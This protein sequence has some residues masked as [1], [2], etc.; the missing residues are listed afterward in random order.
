MPG[1]AASAEEEHHRLV[2]QMRRNVLANYLGQ[3]WSGVMALAFVPVYIR[4]LGVEAYGLIGIFAVIQACLSWVDIGISSVMGREMARFTAGEQSRQSVG[5]RLRTLEIVSATLAALFA[6]LIWAA[7][8]YLATSWV[9]SEHLPTDSVA[10]AVALMGLIVSLRFGEAVYRGALL[11][12]QRQ[13]LYN[14]ANAALATVR[15]LG[16]VLVLTYGA[17]TIQMFFVWQAAVSVVTVS[18]LALSVYGAIGKGTHGA[19]ASSASLAAIRGFATG[20]VGV[21]ILGLLL[22]QVDKVLLSRLVPLQVFGHYALAGTVASALYMLIGPVIQAAY[23]RMVELAAR[24]DTA[25]LPST[26]HQ[27]AQLITVA[28]APVA[29]VLAAFSAAVVF[30]WSGD[31]ELARRTSPIL[32]PLVLGTFLNGLMWLPY[33]CQLAHG[34]T[35]LAFKVNLAAVMM[36]VP[37]ILQ[38]VPAYGAIGAAWIWVILNAGYVI[39]LVQLMHRR[40]MPR[41]KW[42]WYISDVALPAGTAAAVVIIARAVLPSTSQTRAVWVATLILIGSFAL[43]A[44]ALT[45]ERVRRRLAVMLWSQASDPA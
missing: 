33:Q 26:Y 30:A 42:R 11:G 31:Q 12:L 3:A 44:S 39:V 41:E 6:S 14:M 17:P 13:V 34:W 20:V 24:D 28:T 18:I 9:Q 10:N 15:H 27:A 37:A 5:D 38:V 4:W 29:A 22:T 21:T 19:R 45:A 16:A 43:A 35:G 32:W 25:A 40:I 2:S 23:P 36:L 7:A 8:G 1:C